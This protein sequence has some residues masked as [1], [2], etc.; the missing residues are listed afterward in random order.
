MSLESILA[1]NKHQENRCYGKTT[2]RPEEGQSWSTSGK[3]QSSQ[4]EAKAGQ[5]IIAPPIAGSSDWKISTRVT[6]GAISIAVS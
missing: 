5:D 3:Q 6:A 2:S 1:R 4:G